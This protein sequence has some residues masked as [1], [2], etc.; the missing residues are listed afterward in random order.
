MT[1]PSPLEAAKKLLIGASIGSCTCNTKSPELIWHAPNC[2]YVA[3]MM[4]LENIEIADSANE[5]L[6]G[7]PHWRTW[8][9]AVLDAGERDMARIADPSQSDRVE[10][11]LAATE[12]AKLPG[13]VYW[14][15]AKG[16]TRPDEPL[17]AIQITDMEA[18]KIAEA[19][20]E[21]PADCIRAAASSLTRPE[22]S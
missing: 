2:R 13:D 11:A 9:G 3:L 7:P 22:R 8:N 6:Q 16:R 14:L 20:A 4:A 15:L 18:N 17:W 12:L 19:E 10:L 21:R 1:E 5:E